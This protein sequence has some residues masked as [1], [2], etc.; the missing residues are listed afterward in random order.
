MQVRDGKTGWKDGMEK[1]LLIIKTFHV[2]YTGASIA[3]SFLLL[4]VDVVFESRRLSNKRRVNRACVTFSSGS[5]S[6]SITA[7]KALS[8]TAGVQDDHQ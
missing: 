4:Q 2:T 1:Q 5:S 8:F 6:A 3:C 7:S